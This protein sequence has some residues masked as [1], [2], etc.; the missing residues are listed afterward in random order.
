MAQHVKEFNI[1]CFRGIRNLRLQN[2]NDINVLTGDNN[3]GKT[4]YWKLSIF[5]WN[6]RLT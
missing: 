5:K 4:K 1:E 6:N 3:A 2:L